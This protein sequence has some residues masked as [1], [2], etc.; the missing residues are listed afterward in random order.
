MCCRL[1]HESLAMMMRFQIPQCYQLPD[2]ISSAML[3]GHTTD[4]SFAVLWAV[5]LVRYL[6][7]AISRAKIVSAAT[8]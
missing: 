6:E 8:T 2:F 5:Q 3:S 4:N 1:R 7:P